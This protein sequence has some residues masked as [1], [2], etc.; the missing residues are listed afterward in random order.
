VTSQTDPHVDLAD[1]ISSSI[2]V[3][4]LK[5]K[6]RGIVASKPDKAGALVLMQT[7]FASAYWF[8]L[9][10]EAKHV[11]PVNLHSS[12]GRS[13][14]AAD[15]ALT[16]KIAAKCVWARVDTLDVTKLTI[17]HCLAFRLL[18]DPSFASMLDLL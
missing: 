15:T 2:R 1:S 7:S 18:D 9:V 4:D 10:A 16:Q 11:H 6:G 5:G 17:A 8:E 3:A 14:R 13:E 12:V